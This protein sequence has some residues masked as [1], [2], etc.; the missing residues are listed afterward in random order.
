MKKTL[1]SL[2]V[3]VS[4][5]LLSFNGVVAASP[6]IDAAS[7]YDIN[8]QKYKCFQGHYYKTYDYGMDWNYARVQCEK[9]GGHLVTIE[10][11]G[12]QYFV[13][14]ILG[15]K[16]CYWLGGYKDT[17]GIWKWVTGRRIDYQAWANGQPD[18]FKGMENV[19]MMY[20]RSNPL[21][22]TP[23]GGWNDVRD[24]GECNGEPFFGAGNFGFVCEWESKENIR[25][26]N[27]IKVGSTIEEVKK[28]YG[29]PDE[30]RNFKGVSYSYYQLGSNSNS[31][32]NLGPKC[33][34]FQITNGRVRWITA[35]YWKR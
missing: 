15:N 27:G 13:M 8:G 14:N 17:N 2:L 25:Q 20:N 10:S 21:N 19:L 4:L 26:V 34:S 7:E 24:D 16:N 30:E 35:Q 22:P 28:A 12:E 18:N 32:N 1:F 23:R 33:I 29:A 11:K 6:F 9:M 3:L 5:F 31:N